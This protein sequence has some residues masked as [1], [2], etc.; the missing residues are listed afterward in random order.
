MT[1]RSLRLRLL[2]LALLWV[3][4]SLL[5]ATLVLQYLFAINIER[6]MRA[7]MEATLSRL[8]AVIMPDV[9]TPAISTPLPDSR[10]AVPL[11]GKY[12]Q[13]E[14]VETGEQTRSR[15]LWDMQLAAPEV[16][17]SAA[18]MSHVQGP[19]DGHVLVL[20]R[21]LELAGPQG[22]RF[23]RVTVGED[24]GPIDAAISSFNSDA[25]AVVTLL[26]ALLILAAWLQI[27]LGLSPLTVLQRGIEAV[28][29]GTAERLDGKFPTEIA[30]LVEE[31]NTLLAAREGSLEKARARAADLAH[32]LKTPLAALHGVAERLRDRGNEREAALIDDLAFQMSER[33]DHQLRL[34]VLH[35]RTGVHVT[36]TSLNTAVLR[37]LTV[38]KKTSRGENLHW[39]AQLGDDCQ[40]DMH[41]QDLLEL[42]GIVLENAA[43]WADTQVTVRGWRD[44]GDA[45]LAIEDDG[46][47]IDEDQLAR[48]GHRGVRLD[49]S[50]QGTGLGLAMAA[51]I[52][53]MNRGAIAYARAES[54]G[55]KVTLTLPLAAPG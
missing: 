39:V 40:V 13:I 29:R 9:R 5:A 2:A 17:G 11:S 4:V 25:A 44:G 49:E 32:G 24:H 47:G 12:W 6:T 53:E 30:P 50:K 31:V 18:V 38:L 42:V 14:D 15:S 16:G 21:Q 23:Y 45:R 52:L 51:E 54:G 28:R 35:Q 37:T 46:P 22:P 55:L 3:M 34:A 10:Y 27:L 19:A 1:P 43:K 48:L 26:G 36:S 20:T 41:R 7:D 33:V 8:A